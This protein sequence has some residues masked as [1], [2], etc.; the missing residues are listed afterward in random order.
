VVYLAGNVT[1]G[2]AGVII[3]PDQPGCAAGLPQ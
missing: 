3:A 2:K 1:E